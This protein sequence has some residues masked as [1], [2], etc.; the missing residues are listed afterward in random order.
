M[1]NAKEILTFIYVSFSFFSI[2]HLFFL[3]WI[4]VDKKDN[5]LG[6]DD[7]VTTLP[8][9]NRMTEKE[10]FSLLG[11]P[12]QTLE[13]TIGTSPGGVLRVELYNWYP[14]DNQANLLVPIKESWWERENETLVVWFHEIGGRWIVLDTCK[15]KIGFVF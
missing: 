14:P 6:V 1:N 2:D 13:Y 12:D 11:N 9:L 8:F 10:G 15:W 5:D 3:K 7:P 4:I